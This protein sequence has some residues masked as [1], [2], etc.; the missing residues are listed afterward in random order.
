MKKAYLA[1]ALFTALS[2]IL[3]FAGPEAAAQSNLL[4]NPGLESGNAGSPGDWWSHSY[5][6]GH[7]SWDIGIGISHNHNGNQAWGVGN[8]WG[9]AG[10]WGKNT[11]DLQIPVPNAG[12]VFTFTMW[13]SGEQNYAGNAYLT[14]EFYDSLDVLLKSYQ[15]P[16]HS[17]AFDWLHESVSGTAPSGT[18]KV[19]VNAVS[20]NMPMGTGSSYVWFDDGKVAA[21]SNK[22]N[23]FSFENNYGW[24]SCPDWWA[25]GGNANWKG[26]T[27]GTTNEGSWALGIGNDWGPQG[28]TGY[29][30]QDLYLTVN[31]GDSVTFNMWLKSEINYSGNASLKLEFLDSNNTVI[32]SYQSPVYNG[33]F[34]WSRAEV[35]GTVPSGTAKTRAYCLSENMPTGSGSSI[36]YFDNGSVTVQTQA[37][38]KEVVSLNGTWDIEPSETQPAAWNHSIAVPGLVDLAQP[39]FNW[40]SYNY[41]WYK[42]TFTLTP[43][44]AHSNAF[45]KLEQSQYGT[46]VWLNGTYLGS[47][48]GCYTSHKYDATYA[49]NYNGENT[50]LVKVGKWE[51]LPW[52]SSA[53]GHDGEKVSNIPGIWGDVSLILAGNPMIERVQMIPHIDTQIAEARVTLR[54]LESA[55]QNVTLSLT[56]VEK[57]SGLPASVEINIPCALSPLQETTLTVNVPI[58]NMQLWSPDS[59]FLY[60]MV[61]SVKKNNAQ[62]DTLTTTFGMREFTIVGSDFYLNGNKAFLR[63]GNIAFHRFLSDPERA[64]LPWDEIWIKKVLIDIPKAD[65]FNFFRNHV[66]HIYNKWYDIADQYGMMFQDEWA[67]G[68]VTGTEEVIRAEF[69][70]W[71]YDN[72]NHPSIIIWDG[73]NENQDSTVKNI[74]IPQMKALDSTRPW[75]AVDFIEDHPYIYSLGPV[76]NPG[77]FGFSRS[78]DGIKNS[79]TPTDVN[80]FIWFWLDKDG[81]PSLHTVNVM[82]RWLGNNSTVQQQLE[83]QAFIATELTELWR[84]IGVDAIAPFVYLS[85]NGVNTSNWFMGNIANAEVKPIMSALKNAYAPFGVSIEF[86]DRHFFVNQEKN[87]D[88]YIFNDYPISKSGILRCRIVD[89]NDVEVVNVGDFII[90]VPASQTLIRPVLWTMPSAAGTYYLKAELIPQGEVMPFAVSKKVAHVAAQMAVPSN[91]LS[92]K[93]MVYDPDNEIT[94]YLV[95]LGLNAVNYDSAQLAS[96]DI[97]IL[98]EGALLDAS[99]NSRMAEI[100]TFVKN[101]HTLLVTEPDYG[102]TNYDK[103]DYALLPDLILSMNKRLDPESHGYDSYCFAENLNFSL[104]NNISA[105]HLKMFNGGF[106]GEIISQADVELRRKNLILA[107]SNI[108]LEQNDVVETTWGNGIIAVSRIEVRG[109]LTEDADPGT[110]LYS[111][112]VDP[113]A[114][115]YLLNLLSIYLDTASNWQRMNVVLGGLPDFAIASTEQN[116]PYKANYAI[117]GNLA[118][119]WSSKSTDQE[120]IYIGYLEPKTFNVVELN[121]EAAYGRQYNIQISS[122]AVNWTPIYT[123]TN[124]TGGTELINVGTQTANYIKM[125]GIQRVNNEWGYSLW[126]FNVHQV[127]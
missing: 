43:S 40:A 31:A 22:L 16:A 120:W 20:E 87:T 74:I 95:S 23:N 108:L 24:W 101:G 6:N 39:S 42:K 91:I 3:Q 109:R 100:D 56:A 37:A 5:D 33:A 92:A 18:N 34:N 82:P 103:M 28:A 49:L 93:I 72:W 69:T 21:A 52:D 38:S 29:G 123:Q 60:G 9:N 64:N 76:L 73:L 4:I 88:V 96:K 104:W 65:N 94:N 44:Q 111:R 105:E 110:D 98:G 50:L 61:A 102:I 55:N 71:L 2:V 58:L 53:K 126:E 107:R 47:Y 77:P 17:G 13:M 70:Q 30:L 25:T 32:A 78:I 14:L 19:K 125:Q 35:S 59:P 124:G 112:R 90:D 66:G 86:W 51:N 89:Q 115:Q 36:V 75:E 97:L 83:F 11:Q 118:T 99:Y 67:F 54:N 57:V 45:I 114:Q 48:N 122:D 79:T 12:D 15:S 116:P 27:S 62:T 85:I 63:G 121:W 8:D 80:E 127:N 41:F 117:D 81:N 26:A 106:G 68:E 84:R 10:G 119:R 113:V 1:G 46:E 7:P